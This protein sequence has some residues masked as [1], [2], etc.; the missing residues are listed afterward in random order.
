MNNSYR[1][2]IPE[3]DQSIDIPI[4]IKWDFNGHTDSIELYEDEVVEDLV[5]LPKDFEISKFGHQSY[6][7]F[8]QTQLQYQFHF[9]DGLSVDISSSLDSNWVN[10]YQQAGFS[11]FELYYQ[12]NSVIKSFFKLDFYDSNNSLTQK[13]Y[14]TIIIST[15]STKKETVTMNPVLAT[16]ADIIIPDFILDYIIPQEGFF[17]YWLRD[18]EILELDEFYMSVKFFDAKTGNFIRMMTVPQSQLTG[19]KFLFEQ[20]DFFY[21]KVKLDYDTFTYQIY[22]VIT[23]SREGDGTPI[24]W[25]EYVNPPKV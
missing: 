23:N 7:V 25:Y 22:N 15:S 10:S 4:E 20:K 19:N 1:F 13:N 9:F 6:G 16:T 21:R 8:N 3:N 17:I 5:G 18:F 14:F 2:I 11:I 12:T 24:K